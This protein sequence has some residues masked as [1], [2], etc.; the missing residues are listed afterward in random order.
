L[1]Q[2]GRLVVP[3]SADGG[4]VLTRVT[5]GDTGQRNVEEIGPCRF[6]PLIGEAGY[7]G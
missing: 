4:E 5:L 6:V 3:V 1:E 2:G 7:E